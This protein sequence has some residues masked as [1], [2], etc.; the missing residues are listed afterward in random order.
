MIPTGKFPTQRVMIALIAFLLTAGLLFG[1][2]A[3][4]E[5]L[6]AGP[7][8][9]DYWKAQGVLDFKTRDQ[10]G[11]MILEVKAGKIKSLRPVMERLI[12]QIEK[13]KGRTVTSVEFTSAKA[14]GLENAYDQLSFALAEAQATGRY[15]LL[16]TAERSVEQATG[17]NARVEV[18]DRFL[19]VNLEK[20]KERLYRAIGRPTGL[21]VNQSVTGGGQ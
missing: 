1:G 7:A 20:G 9:Y 6:K 10:A 5:H 18:G 14:S 4:A 11:G 8:N 13:G 12:A 16:P 15:M 2:Y 3:L 21:A 17:V 19:F